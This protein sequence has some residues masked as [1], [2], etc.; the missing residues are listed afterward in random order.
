M[1]PIV[2][3]KFLPWLLSYVFAVILYTAICT[4]LSYSGISDLL[5]RLLFLGSRVFTIIGIIIC[6]IY[7][8]LFAL[9]LKHKNQHKCKGE[10]NPKT[11]SNFMVNLRSI[12]HALCNKF[13]LVGKKIKY[14]IS[15]IN[16]G[17]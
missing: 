2:K 6:V 1:F 14:V 5:F 10:Y 17:G 8:V 13:S 11:P 16:N 15:L 9:N 3:R 12:C 7:L 4:I